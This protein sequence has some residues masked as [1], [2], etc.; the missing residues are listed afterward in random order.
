MFVRIIMT[1]SPVFSSLPQCPKKLKKS[2]VQHIHS[3]SQRLVRGE[4]TLQI[5]HAL[6]NGFIRTSTPSVLLNCVLSCVLCLR[7]VI[8]EAA[9]VSA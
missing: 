5:V 7:R 6:V 4:T 1:L 8:G 3:E 2:E 9:Q